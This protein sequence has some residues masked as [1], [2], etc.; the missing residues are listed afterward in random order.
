DAIAEEPPQRDIDGGPGD[1]TE[2]VPEEESV[3]RVAGRAANQIDPGSQGTEQPPGD[4]DA[5]AAPGIR[6]GFHGLQADAPAEQAAEPGDDSRPSPSA[7]GVAGLIAED[8]T[9]AGCANSPP[10]AHGALRNHRARDN[11]KERD[12]Q[13]RADGGNGHDAEKGRGAILGNRRQELIVHGGGAPGGWA[14][15]SM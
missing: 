15:G 7:D 10:E 3:P 11:Q 5:G 6:F 12:G 9:G 8:G 13:R 2:D 4:K 1:F 14:A